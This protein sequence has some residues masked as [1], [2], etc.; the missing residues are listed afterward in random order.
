MR[1]DKTK[2]DV[3]T[4]YFE[5]RLIKRHEKISNKSDYKRAKKQQNKLHPK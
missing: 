4:G 5:H 3:L 1:R 2:K